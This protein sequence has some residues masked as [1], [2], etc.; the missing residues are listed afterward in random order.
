MLQRAGFNSASSHLDS[1]TFTALTISVGIALIEPT[2]E[3]SARGAL[4]LAD[5]ALLT[6]GIFSVNPAAL[7]R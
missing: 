6:T 1:R 7:C 2:R 3:R 5:H 4:Q